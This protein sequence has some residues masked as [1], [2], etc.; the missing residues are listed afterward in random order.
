[1]SPENIKMGEGKPF[2]RF[3]VIVTNAMKLP[4]L[5][6]KKRP[7]VMTGPL[8]Q[9]TSPTTPLQRPWRAS[10]RWMVLGLVDFGEGVEEAPERLGAEGFVAGGAPFTD[11]VGD[12]FRGY[13]AEVHGSDNEVVRGPVGD[14]TV[15]VGVDA[16]IKPVEAVAQFADRRYFHDGWRDLRRSIHPDQGAPFRM[17]GILRI[18]GGRVRFPVPRGWQSWG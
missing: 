10:L 7:A 17:G 4:L 6:P 15:A 11:H 3:F 12:L 16:T 2:S 1:M 5:R 14:R 18:Q 9:F 8:L 13:G